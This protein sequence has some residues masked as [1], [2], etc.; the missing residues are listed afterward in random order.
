MAVAQPTSQPGKQYRQNS[1]GKRPIF[2][3]CFVSVNII[4]RLMIT[5]ITDRIV[6]TMDVGHCLAGSMGGWLVVKYCFLVRYFIQCDDTLPNQEEDENKFII[7][8]DDRLDRMNF[9]TQSNR[10]FR[11]LNE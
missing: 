6:H 4:F 1:S 3:S 5:I 8:R 9:S 11:S 2:R 10:I 7:I